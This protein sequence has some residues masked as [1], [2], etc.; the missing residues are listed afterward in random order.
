MIDQVLRVSTGLPVWADTNSITVTA[1]NVGTGQG[2]FKQKTGNDLEF[3]TILAGSTK[4]SVVG[5]TDDVTLDVVEANIGH[6]N[7][8]GNGTNDRSAVDVGESKKGKAQHSGIG[9]ALI[10][11]AKNLSKEAKF[12]KLAVISSIGTR[13]YYSNRGFNLIDLYQVTEL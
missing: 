12:T 8:A 2:V 4:V 7:I 1:S 3:K 6:A 11:E 5:N 10:K 9:K 13:Q